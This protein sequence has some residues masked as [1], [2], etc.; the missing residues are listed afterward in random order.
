MYVV[1][2]TT[3]VMFIYREFMMEDYEQIDNSE[4]ADVTIDALEKAT[5]IRFFATN[6]INPF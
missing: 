3:C 5:N 1:Q 4:G 6:Y 2:M